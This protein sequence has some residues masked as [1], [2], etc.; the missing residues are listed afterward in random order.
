M[1]ICRRSFALLAFALS[2]GFA[3]AQSQGAGAPEIIRHKTNPHEADSSPTA[4]STGQ[5]TPP[6]A[7]N[8]GKVLDTPTV[9]VIW[10][11]NWAQD[12]GTDTAGGQAIIRDFLKGL[13]NSNYYLINHSYGTPTGRVNV[14]S[15]YTD[16]GSQGTRLS[17]SD[18]QSI[19]SSAISPGKL[20]SDPNG[21][22]FVLTSSNVAEKSGFCSKYCGWHTSGTLNGSSIKYAF[23]GNAAR[24]LNA[25]AAQTT[26]P[27]GNAG[28]DAMVSVIAHE[29]EEANTDPIPNSGWADAKG[30]ENA[31]KCAWTFGQT[32][33]HAPNG[34]YFNVT[35]PPGTGRN[36][37]IQRNLDVNSL[38]FIDYPKQQ[39]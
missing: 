31:D 26:G 21:V 14:G 36:Y 2:L 3:N 11:G 30:A 19:V 1:S 6:I 24:C 38:C 39:Q 33:G 4:G 23:V 17:D 20:P 15:E 18:V 35:L 22:Y 28:V 32:L 37:L 25:C 29:L 16:P 7:Y 8:G 10:Y 13:D 12:N 34:A 9:Y 27:N 5:I